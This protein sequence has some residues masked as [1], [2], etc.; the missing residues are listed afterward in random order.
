[1]LLKWFR[2]VVLLPFLWMAACSSIPTL[3]ND[4]KPG[5]DKDQVLDRVGNPKRTFRDRGYD[6]WT[7]I[8]HNN[9]QWW[10]RDV[11]FENGKVIKVTR[12]TLNSKQSWVSGLENAVTMEEY[13]HRARE[14]Q[15]DSNQF[16]SIDGGG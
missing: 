9:N 16:K 8:Y 6:N 11:V 10:R 4:I 7:Y 12:P 14:H 15:K 3:L 1:M 5:M 13:E 2:F